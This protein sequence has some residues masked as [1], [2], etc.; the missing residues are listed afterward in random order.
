MAGDY[1][2]VRSVK[3]NRPPGYVLRKDVLFVGS[4]EH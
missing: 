2:E 1:L 4:E 3:E